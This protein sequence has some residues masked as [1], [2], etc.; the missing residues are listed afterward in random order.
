LIIAEFC[1]GV[2]FEKF[3]KPRNEATIIEILGP[4][5]CRIVSHKTSVGIEKAIV[6]LNCCIILYKFCHKV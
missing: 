5:L 1:G 4:Y 6:Q 2:I 3:V